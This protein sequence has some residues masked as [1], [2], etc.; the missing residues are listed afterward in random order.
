MFLPYYQ[1]HDK[2]G[3]YQM[4]LNQGHE[5]IQSND[6]HQIVSVGDYKN[7]IFHLVHILV[8]VDSLQYLLYY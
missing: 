6:A 5:I 8:S 1:Y 7:Q 2:I 4:D 3:I